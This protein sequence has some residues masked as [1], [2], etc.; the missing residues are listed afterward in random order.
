[1][2][3][4]LNRT[5]PKGGPFFGTCFLCGTPNLALED[6]GKDCPNQRG[7][8]A[9]EAVV[10]AVTGTALSSHEVSTNNRGNE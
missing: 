7:L 3:H 5:S 2:K 1:V 4:A 10:E 9:D 8:T 6:M